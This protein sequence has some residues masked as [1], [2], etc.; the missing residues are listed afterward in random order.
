[1]TQTSK[2]NTASLDGNYAAFGQVIE[3]IEVVD[4]IAKVDT[5]ENDKPKSTVKIAVA[6]F[7]REEAENALKGFPWWGILLIVLGGAAIVAC[8]CVLVRNKTKEAR[9]A[10]ENAARA[11]KKTNTKKKR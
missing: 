8:V 11:N 1:M 3:G 9:L 5:D 6:T 4:K 10:A 2:N 7:D